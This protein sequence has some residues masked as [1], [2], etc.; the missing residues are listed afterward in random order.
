MAASRVGRN[1]TTVSTI[2]P[3]R[4]RAAVDGVVRLGDGLST[5]TT[6]R[7]RL[8]PTRTKTKKRKAMRPKKS[9]K[10]VVLTT[11]TLYRSISP[12]ALFTH[13]YQSTRIKF[14]SFLPFY[15]LLNALRL[16]LSRILSFKPN[17][18]KKSNKRSSC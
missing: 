18:Q 15:Q 7:A 11:L 1:S 14:S 4:L 2:V 16:A 9:S 5:R 10:R 3:R 6:G 8:P 17:Q 13:M 12:D